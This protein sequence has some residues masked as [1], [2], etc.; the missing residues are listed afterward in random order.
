MEIGIGLDQTL[1]LSFE[2]QRQIVR[3]ATQLGYTSAWTPAG[4]VARDSFQICSQWWQA[5]DSVASGGITT[6]ISVL[7]VTFWSAPALAASAGTVGELTGGH[8]ILGLG[9]GGAYQEDFRRNF[10]LRAYKPIALM[11]DYLLTVRRLL[12]GETVDY[13][14]QAV[15]LRHTK[16]AFAPPPVPVYLGALGPQMLRLAGEAA[17]GAS[18]NWCTPEQ[19]AWSRRRIEEGARRAGRAA[20]DIRVVEYIRICV[21]DDEDVARRAFTRAMLGY[22]LARPGAS[23]EHGYRAHFGRMGFEA[24]LTELEARIEQGVK[25]DEIVERFPRELLQMVGYYGP[26]AGAAAAFRRLAVGL[27]VA[28][29]RVVAA[30][31]GIESV[32]A[33][34]QACRPEAITA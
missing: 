28:M 17:D 29:V 9:T 2:Q 4:G 27:D 10:D 19:I 3:E 13:E 24:A 15:T 32:R 23:K 25:L 26:A 6:G 34:M 8:F 16:L 22:A 30:R 33:V 12:A 5:S 21:D 14:G 31:P 18:L 20:A 7:P 1:R 11:R